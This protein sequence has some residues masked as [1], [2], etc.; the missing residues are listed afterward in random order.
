GDLYVADPGSAELGSAAVVDVFDP[1]N[2]PLEQ[3][4][5][6][7]A[8]GEPYSRDVAISA[9]GTLYVADSGPVV[10]HVLNALGEEQT[11]W[12]GAHSPNESSGH[13]YVSV[14][15]DNSTNPADARKGDVYV[16]ATT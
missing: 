13:G 6:K 4:G 12:S 8:L 9:T 16:Q 11:A 7:A 14:A 10:V 15:V 5:S 3:F 1:S 2:E